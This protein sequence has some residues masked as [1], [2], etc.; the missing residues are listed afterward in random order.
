[1]DWVYSRHLYK[2]ILLT[3]AVMPATQRLHD[4][5][6]SQYLA[7]RPCLGEQESLD[8]PSR[9]FIEFSNPPIIYLVHPSI[10]SLEFRTMHTKA[11]RI[12]SHRVA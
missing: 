12:A 10:H 8:K 3:R 2:G 6:T 11:H 7:R 1:M 4:I 5:S 9:S